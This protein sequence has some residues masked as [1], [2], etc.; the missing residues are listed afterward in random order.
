MKSAP[1][2]SARTN[3]PTPPRGGRR[4]AGRTHP[5]TAPRPERPRLRASTRGRYSAPSNHLDGVPPRM[6]RRRFRTGSPAARRA[7]P[8]SGARRDAPPEPAR[9]MAGREPGRAMPEA[10]RPKAGRRRRAASSGRAHRRAPCAR[11]REAPPPGE[12]DAK[13]LRPSPCI[14]QNRRIR[15][16]VDFHDACST[17]PPAWA[18]Q[19]FCVR[20]LLRPS[21]VL[22]GKPPAHPSTRAPW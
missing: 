2:P 9:F 10:R 16:Y 1:P 6:R 15:S 11:R 5:G 14:T 7:P 22:L 19:N 21:A 12:H 18:C 20:G 13:K 8:A 17:A 3:I 4:K